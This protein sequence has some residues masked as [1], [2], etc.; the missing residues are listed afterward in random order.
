MEAE[1]RAGKVRATELWYEHIVLSRSVYPPDCMQTSMIPSS[2]G[3][4]P[5][6]KLSLEFIKNNINLSSSSGGQS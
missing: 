5:T 3:E 6:P 2:P 4:S 1:L